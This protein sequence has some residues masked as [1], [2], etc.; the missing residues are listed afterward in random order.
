MA[1]TPQTVDALVDLIKKR[2]AILMESR[3]DQVF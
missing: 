3:R 2:H 1:R